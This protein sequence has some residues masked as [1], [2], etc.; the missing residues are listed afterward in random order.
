MPST[1]AILRLGLSTTEPPQKEQ[2]VGESASSLSSIVPLLSSIATGSSSLDKTEPKPARYLVAKGLP[3]LPTKLVEKVWNFEFVEMEE[4]LPTPRALR[5][6]EQG[7]LT[8]GDTGLEYDIQFWMKMAASADRAWTCEDPWQ[9]I[10]CLPGQGR[11]T[12]PFGTSKFGVPGSKGKG[13]WPPGHEEVKGLPSPSAKR[14]KKACVSC[15]TQ[16]PGVAP[17]G[18]SVYLS[19]G[20]LAVEQ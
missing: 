19:T 18:V 3:T 4:F 16:P 2:G 1:E 12:D 17:M 11:P 6:A 8:E 15:T 5:I 10:S 7:I 13:K 9:Y 20:V 14:A